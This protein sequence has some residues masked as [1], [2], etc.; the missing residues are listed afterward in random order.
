MTHL[1]D[2]MDTKHSECVLYDWGGLDEKLQAPRSSIRVS[3]TLR[4]DRG[5]GTHLGPFTLLST[6]KPCSKPSQTPSQ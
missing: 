3:M 4:A 2:R 6:S 1:I 5:Q